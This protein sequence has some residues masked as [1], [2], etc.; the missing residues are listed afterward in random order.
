MKLSEI[1]KG[2]A[3]PPA[4]RKRP[5]MVVVWIIIVAIAILAASG[6]SGDE[7]TESMP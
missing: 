6:F 2:E 5:N 4:D 1:I 3:L 7:K